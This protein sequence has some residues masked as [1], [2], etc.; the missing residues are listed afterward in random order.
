MTKQIVI[1]SFFEKGSELLLINITSWANFKSFMLS[2]EKTDT[3]I[4]K[5]MIPFILIFKKAKIS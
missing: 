2:G 4:A 1:Y 5:Y 3:K